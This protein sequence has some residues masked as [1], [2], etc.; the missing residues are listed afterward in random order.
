MSHFY[1][2]FLSAAEIVDRPP[3]VR[4]GVIQ[5]GD[6]EERFESSIEFWTPA[7]YE[8][9]W[10]E[11][12]GRLSLKTPKSCLITSITDPATGNFLFWWPMYLIG[13]HVHFQNHVLFI[14]EIREAFDPAKPYVHVP[15]RALYNEDG[16]PISEWII[17][18]GEVVG[19]CNAIAGISSPVLI[20]NDSVRS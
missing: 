10:A 20:P 8:S 3:R 18:F 6:F 5:I 9:H 14:S 13:Q 17:P 16:E 1:I 15:E 19:A 7:Q 12:L 4:L 11:A 2:R